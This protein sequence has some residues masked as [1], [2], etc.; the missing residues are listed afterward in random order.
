ML[1][2]FYTL[3]LLFTSIHFYTFT[4][5]QLFLFY[6]FIFLLHYFPTF[7]S[8]FVESSVNSVLLHHFYT[9]LRIYHGKYKIRAPSVLHYYY[10][11]FILLLAKPKG[12]GLPLLP[13]F[14]R[15][16]MAKRAEGP[17]FLEFLDFLDFLER[18]DEWG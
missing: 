1:L 12:M 18:C 4:P 16:L 14:R 10:T 5:L 8:G 15:S 2:H 3:T 11:T 6:T 9:I 13:T 7:P 17:D